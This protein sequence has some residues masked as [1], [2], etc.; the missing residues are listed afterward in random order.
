M[1]DLK[2][3]EIARVLNQVSSCSITN[4]LGWLLSNWGAMKFEFR[5]R[6]D[7]F[8]FVVFI[9]SW[10]KIQ[11]FTWYGLKNEQTDHV[12]IVA[13]TCLNFSYFV[14]F[15]LAFSAPWKTERPNYTT[16]NHIAA[17][18]SQ[19]MF[20]RVVEICRPTV[21]TEKEFLLAESSLHVNN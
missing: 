12:L 3:N 21:R 9:C 1:Y 13:F 6:C 4:H 17:I 18:I 10:R 5:I 15:V 2:L 14:H 7:D 16:H 20:F 8:S 11:M 19:P